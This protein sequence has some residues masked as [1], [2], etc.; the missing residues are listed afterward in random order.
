MARTAASCKLQKA[1]NHQLAAER[2]LSEH[3][4]NKDRPNGSKT[5]GRPL[6]L[7]FPPSPY[8]SPIV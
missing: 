5:R 7:H 2:R 8:V 4:Y 6:R 1:N 3:D